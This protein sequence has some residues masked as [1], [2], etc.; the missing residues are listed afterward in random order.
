VFDF[1]ADFGHLLAGPSIYEYIAGPVGDRVTLIYDVLT[2]GLG[3]SL[4]VFGTYRMIRRGQWDRLAIG[5][6]V[7]LGAGA[8]CTIGGPD[9]IRPQHERYGMFLIVPS[10]VYMACCLQTLIPSGSR[11]TWLPRGSLVLALT[12]AVCGSSLWGFRRFYFDVLRT[13]GGSAHLTYR[14]AAIE[15]K[16]RAMAIILRDLASDPARPPSGAGRRVPIIADGW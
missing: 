4:T 7:L 9:S 5:A 8:I 6:G 15:P 1:L 11:E 16:Q 10:M 13:T 14:T 3:V 2:W 12:L